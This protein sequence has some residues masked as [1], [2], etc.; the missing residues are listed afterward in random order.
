MEGLGQLVFI[1]IIII[2]AMLDAIGRSRKRQR[3]MEEMEREEGEAEAAGEG[4]LDTGEAPTRAEQEERETADAM[5]P[6]DLWAILTGQAPAEAPPERQPREEPP[7]RP[8]IP[9]PVPGDRYVTR[10][11]EEEPAEE[12]PPATRRGAGWME[13]LDREERRRTEEAPSPSDEVL[14]EEAA[15]YGLPGEPWGEIEDISAGEIGRGADLELDV[16]EGEEE[17]PARRRAKAASPY[18]D[19]LQSGDRG[20]LR[21][22][23]VLSEVL[24]TPAG[25]RRIGHDWD[26]R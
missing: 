26:D 2:A 7:R 25:F 6:D 19:L 15:V 13:G 21:K 12:A 24:G 17:R 5:V 20:D 14:A 4:W 3:R 18:V 23:I 16:A 9:A 10:D 11:E 1:L 8:H 22:A